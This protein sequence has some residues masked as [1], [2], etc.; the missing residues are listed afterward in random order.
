[1]LNTKV[2]FWQRGPVAFWQRGLTLEMLIFLMKFSSF[3]FSSAKFKCFF[4]PSIISDRL[5][6]KLGFYLLYVAFWQHGMDLM[7]ILRN[8]SKSSQISLKM[9]MNGCG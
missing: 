1:M 2:A 9:A 5:M 7:Y 4:V 8:W 3:G 6:L